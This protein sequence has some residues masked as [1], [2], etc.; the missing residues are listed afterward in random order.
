MIKT[1][2]MKAEDFL[3]VFK[4]LPDFAIF[5]TNTTGGIT[6]WNEGARNI[7]GYDGDEIIGQH[8]SRIFPAGDS[9]QAEWEIAEARTRGR[10]DDERWHERKNRSRFWGSGILSAVRGKD[11]RLKGFVKILRDLT[12]RKKAED[13]N[14]KLLDDLREM[15]QL[16]DRFLAILSH[17]LR[18]PLAA[19]VGWSSLLQKN[20][21]KEEQV[22]PAIENIFR[23]ANTQAGLIQD[24]LDMSRIAAGQLKIEA[25]AVDIARALQNALDSVRFMAAAKQ[26]RIETEVDEMLRPTRGDPRRIQQIL[27]NLLS[28]AIKF[29][30]AR[31]HVMVSAHVRGRTIEIQVTDTGQGMSPDFLPHAFNMFRQEH[32]TT[33]RVQG[34][35]GLGLAIVKELAELHGGKVA[36]FSRGLGKGSRF[37]V[38]LPASQASV[39]PEDQKCREPAGE[40]LRGRRVFVLENDPDCR[41]FVCAVVEDFAGIAESASNVADALA[42]IKRFKPHIIVSDLA[43]PDEDGFSF[44]RR[45]RTEEDVDSTIPVI[46]LTALVSDQ[47]RRRALSE[48]FKAFVAKPVASED[49]V[50]A[51]DEI[52]RLDSDTGF[53]H[54][55]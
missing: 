50:L 5:T 46:A 2:E 24:L 11:H 27:W 37:T 41:E 54:V 29:T 16:K 8:L 6:S 23:N 7:F 9:L 32:E 39:Q 21:L 42:L 53:D 34:G 15:G 10:A 48:G 38:A 43:L 35:L 31:G 25:G 22:Q 14:T 33:S 55:A 44:I 51:I 28:N 49:L 18:T 52:L 1:A 19:I 20:V 26:I 17:E 4:S 12:T 13:E 3:G 40:I 36:A 45:L 30:P 47:I